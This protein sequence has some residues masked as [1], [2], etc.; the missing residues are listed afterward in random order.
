MLQK[1]VLRP[2]YNAATGTDVEV[3]VGANRAYLKLSEVPSY[4]GGALSPRHRVMGVQGAPSV[5]TDIDQLQAEEMQ[6][7]KL[8][9]D[10][11]LYILR[12]EK[13]YDITGKLI[14]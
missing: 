1:N 14:K 8:L 6:N 7:T 12:G 13:M 10:G 11:T 5:T 2:T 4:K 9:I 3:E